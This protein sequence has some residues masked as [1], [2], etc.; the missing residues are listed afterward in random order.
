MELFVKQILENDVITS[1]NYFSCLYHR[2]LNIEQSLSFTVVQ[3]NHAGS[4]ASKPTQ[5]AMAYQ[6]GDKPF[7]IA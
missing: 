2:I 3:K 4:V 5:Y 1:W 6:K 7:I